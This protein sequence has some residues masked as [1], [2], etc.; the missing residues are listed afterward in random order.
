M[1]KSI[2]LIIINTLTLIFA[3]VMNGMS[4]SAVFNGS[5]VGEVSDKYS[6]LIAPS[7]YA[8]AIWGLIY[9]FLIM[10]VGYQWY[11]YYKLKQDTEIKQTGLW[12]SLAN[13]ANGFW[14]VA[15]LNE[16]LGTS[17]L[18]IFILLASLI[19]L[20]VRLRLEIWN[21]PKRIIL[22]IWWPIVIY[23]GWIIVASVSNVA[24]YLVSIGW[25]GGFL[26][27]NMWTIIM[28]VVASIIYLWLVF[29]RNL[30][31]AAMVG[32]W[33]LVA[34]SVRHWNVYEGIAIAAIICAG[35]LFVVVSWHGYKNR[36]YSP[37]VQPW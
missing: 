28:I 10:F 24:A 31:E 33:A 25:Q 37:F 9:L 2:T 18:L 27:E 30:R 12:L 34:I 8:F 29:S 17:V 15:W 14:I 20:T 32:V 36:K 11:S 22:F 1:K 6:T 23:L 7:G 21:A 35:I 5:T 13:I 26:S 3:L 16:A 19:V 4:G